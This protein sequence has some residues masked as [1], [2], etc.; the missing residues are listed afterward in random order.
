MFS[1]FSVMKYLIVGLGNIGPEYAGTRHNVGF[2]V[3]NV[4]AEEGGVTFTEERYGAIARMRVKNA[5]LVLLKP[6]TYMNL[7]GNAIR[8]RLQKENVPVE[9]LLVIVDDIALP[10]GSLRLKPGG[11]HAGHNGLRNIEDVLGTAQYCRLRFGIGNAFPRGGQMDYVLG[12]FKPEEL[13]L[14]PE[15]VKQASEIAKSFCLAGVDITMNQ[16]NHK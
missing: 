2:R 10:F 3:V 9:N 12:L 14:M 16:Y 13:E 11:S 15:R 6:N 4:L 1:F 5:E 7:S 8:Y